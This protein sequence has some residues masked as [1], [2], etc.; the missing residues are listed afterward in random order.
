MIG[1]S[2]SSRIFDQQVATVTA[3]TVS[4]L[5]RYKDTALT[6]TADS[7]KEFD[8]HEEV[9]KALNAPAYFADPYSS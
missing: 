4:I 9:T 1:F 8:Y 2:V 5:L 7:S 3:A 6:I